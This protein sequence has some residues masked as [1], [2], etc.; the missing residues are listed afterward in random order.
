MLPDLV[1]ADIEPKQAKM[2]VLPG[3]IEGTQNL[4]ADN[5][6][7]AVLR[8]AAANNCI[9]A[10]I[11]AAPA[12]LVKAGLLDGRRATSHPAAA[13]HMT[14]VEYLEDRVVKDG[15]IITSRAAGTTFE[16]AFALIEQLKNRAAVDEVNRGVLARI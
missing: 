1:F 13:A 3:G 9:I 16:F 12:V 14:G 10:A 15:L 2:I 6:V 4:G 5:R 11:C 8:E 7:I